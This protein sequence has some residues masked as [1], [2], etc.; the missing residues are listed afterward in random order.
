MFFRRN[1]KPPLARAE[2]LVHKSVTLIH[3]YWRDRHYSPS[4]A[5]LKRFRRLEIILFR[6]YGTVRRI[7]IRMERRFHGEPE[8][9]ESKWSR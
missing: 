9:N 2:A 5:D 4:Q 1:P 8:V 3:S 6:S 7:T